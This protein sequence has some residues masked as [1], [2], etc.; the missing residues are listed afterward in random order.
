MKVSRLCIL[1]LG[2]FL[3]SSLFAKELTAQVVDDEVPVSVKNSFNRIY[4]D[5]NPDSWQ[6]SIV[7][8]KGAKKS[9]RYTASYMNEGRQHYVRFDE[10]GMPIGE[11]Y[12][13]NQELS[14]HVTKQLTE[15]FPLYEVKS[16]E[17]VWMFREN[18]SAFKV[19]LIK[20]SKTEIVFVDNDGLQI[21][22]E[23]LIDEF[24]Y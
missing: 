11:F 23:A 22:E 10:R 4:I 13:L 9:K 2:L 16:V 21:F 7:K 19:Q 1:L 15:D 12:E 17:S 3:I 5:H 18:L 8:K 24:S 20:K 14:G 6:L